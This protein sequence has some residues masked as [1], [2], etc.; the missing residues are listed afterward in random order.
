ML[1][2]FMPVIVT[3]NLFCYFLNED[4]MLIVKYDI[5]YKNTS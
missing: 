5:L 3:T 2:H 4:I 1:A